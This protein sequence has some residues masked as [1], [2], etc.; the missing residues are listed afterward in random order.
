MRVY[1]LTTYIMYIIILLLCVFVLY[2]LISSSPN[3]KNANIN[4]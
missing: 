4:N 2:E 1:D 3:I